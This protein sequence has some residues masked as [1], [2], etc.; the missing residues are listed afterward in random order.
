MDTK[1]EDLLTDC[2]QPMFDEQTRDYLRRARQADP[3][4]LAPYQAG[5]CPDCDQPVSGDG[6]VPCDGGAFA[7]VVLNG[8]VILGCGGYFV[9]SPAVLGMDAGGWEA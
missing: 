7:H 3:A 8:S 5:T 6:L 9:I 4:T 1:V 2:G